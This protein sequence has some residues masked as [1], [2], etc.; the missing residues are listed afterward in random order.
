MSLYEQMM[1]KKFKFN[2]ALIGLGGYIAP[3]HVEAIKK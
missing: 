1:N 3:R 2:F